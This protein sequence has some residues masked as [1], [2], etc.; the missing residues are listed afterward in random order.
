MTRVGPC[1]DSSGSSRAGAE[2]LTAIA[3]IILLQGILRIAFWWIDLGSVLVFQLSKC[4][5]RH[6]VLRSHN[7]ERQRKSQR[8]ILS[9]KSIDDQIPLRGSAYT[10]PTEPLPPLAWRDTKRK[11]SPSGIK[12]GLRCVQPGFVSVIFSGVP[13][14]SATLYKGSKRLGVKMITPR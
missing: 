2:G 14:P 3:G 9:A 7:P 5:P 12:Y 4:S 11:W 6:F 10:P 8:T 1:A 13:P